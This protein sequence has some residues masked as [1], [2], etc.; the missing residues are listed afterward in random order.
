MT[1]RRI[2]VA[3]KDLTSGLELA[4]AKAFAAEGPTEVRVLHVCLRE[5]FGRA[6]FD[7]ERPDEAVFVTEAS[8]FELRMAGVGAHGRVRHAPVGQLARAIVEDADGWGADL[9]ILGPSGRSGLAAKLKPAVAHSV[10]RLAT[11][12]VLVARASSLGPRELAT[13]RRRKLTRL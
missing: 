2:C 3:V 11:C 8:V 6:R 5:T 13:A 12:P 4:A 10:T 7:V 9:I 1:L